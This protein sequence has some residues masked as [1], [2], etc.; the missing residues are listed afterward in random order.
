MQ[1]KRRRKSHAWA[2]LSSSWKNIRPP[3]RGIWETKQLHQSKDFQLCV[4]THISRSSPS[5]ARPMG[6]LAGQ[7]AV[8]PG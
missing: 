1:K 3:W 5:L 6:E 4:S 2:P 7:R 8:L